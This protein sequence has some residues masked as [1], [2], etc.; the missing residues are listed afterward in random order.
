[1]VLNRW[2]TPLVMTPV[3]FPEV[4]VAAKH[5]DSIGFYP[6]AIEP[7]GR[8]KE[9]VRNRPSFWSVARSLALSE[10]GRW[11][12]TSTCT[13]W[14]YPAIGA[15]TISTRPVRVRLI[16]ESFVVTAVAAR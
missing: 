7:E 9:M 14:A 3:K 10:V 8:T 12:S 4:S 6:L 11:R 2:I 1:M 16:P 5:P 13:S 15:S